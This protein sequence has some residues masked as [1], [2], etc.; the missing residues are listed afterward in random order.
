MSTQKSSFSNRGFQ[1]HQSVIRHPGGGAH[2]R[3]IHIVNRALRGVR[4]GEHPAPH[5]DAAGKRPALTLDLSFQGM[6]HIPEDVVDLTKED[7]E[8]L[9]I[10]HNLLTCLPTR[11]GTCM[12]LRYLDISNNDLNEFPLSICQLKSLE[13]L[14]VAHNSLGNIPDQIVLLS[15][16]KALFL[17]SNQIGSLPLSVGLM[18]SLQLIKISGNPIEYPP[19]EILMVP[20]HAEEADAIVTARIMSFFRCDAYPQLLIPTGNLDLIDAAD[21][22]ASCLPRLQRLL[23]IDRFA[24][25][26]RHQFNTVSNLERLVSRSGLHLREMQLYIQFA[27]EGDE[28]AQEGL[29]KACVRLV[30]SMSRVCLEIGSNSDMIVDQAGVQDVLPLLSLLHSTCRDLRFAL[31]AFTPNKS[32]ETEDP[33]TS[34][35]LTAQPGIAAADI[36]SAAQEQKSLLAHGTNTNSDNHDQSL[37]S[38]VLSLLEACKA[39]KDLHD[40]LRGQISA[41]WRKDDAREPRMCPVR[42]WSQACASCSKTEEAAS[43]LRSC[44]HLYTPKAYAANDP[45]VFIELSSRFLNSWADLGKG[46][47]ALRKVLYLST[48]VR[49]QLKNTQTTVKRATQLLSI[50]IEQIENNTKAENYI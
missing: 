20:N 49:K 42:S 29:S 26:T 15:S 48:D 9:T 5:G 43:I 47:M 18:E 3:I 28:S 10:S 22:V 14:N 40:Q 38:V 45:S 32:C 36:L 30:R 46:M 13:I 16:L 35:L 34:M 33:A 8:W 1:I 19:P 50:W 11:F 25:L 44:L 31:Q 21:A 39:Y 12:N 4:S 17:Q 6:Q 27:S 2:D 37:D 7:L 41:S 24:R 23:S